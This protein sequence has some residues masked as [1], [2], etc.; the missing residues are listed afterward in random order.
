MS[1]FKNLKIRTRLLIAFMFVAIIMVGT[2]AIAVVDVNNTIAIS[3]EV[4][5]KVIDPLDW[6]LHARV[7]LESNED[8]RT[9]Y[10][11]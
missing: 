4:V 8:R 11:D 9:R 7:L 6:L 5:E 1:K 10:S 2:F 3:D